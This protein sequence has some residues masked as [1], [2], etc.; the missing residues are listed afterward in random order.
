M[1]AKT[2]HH[3]VFRALAIHADARRNCEEA[4]NDVWYVRHWEIIEAVLATAP[5]GSGLDAGISLNYDKSRRDRLVL[6]T[7]FHHMLEGGYA[8]WSEHDL[9]ITPDL[10]FDYNLRIT[11]HNRSDIKD[12]LGDLFGYWLSARVEIESIVGASDPVAT[13]VE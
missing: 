12:Y 13:L 9:V 10:Q 11:G 4:D 7:S 8:G 2:L 5:L 1:N 6:H 3:Q